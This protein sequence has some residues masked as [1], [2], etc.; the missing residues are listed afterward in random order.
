MRIKVLIV[1]LVILFAVEACS[2]KVDMPA[3]NIIERPS[4]N[5]ID[6]NDPNE[7]V[8]TV[9]V[10]GPGVVAQNITKIFAQGNISYGLKLKYITF[11]YNENSF[12]PFLHIGISPSLANHD[13][14]GAT[15]L[16][17]FLQFSA[18]PFHIV[19]LIHDCSE[20]E[21]EIW[22]WKYFYDHEEV[23][24]FHKLEVPL[25]KMTPNFDP[26]Q[27]GTNG[28]LDLNAVCNIEFLLKTYSE[29]ESSI[30]TLAN[31]YLSF[32]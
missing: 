3:I 13:W 12:E 28:R 19:V 21:S 4:R 5:I 2:S 14:S 26:T 1:C 10:Y 25:N 23:D 18:L 27:S 11:E 22:I 16:V 24:E 7:G 15:K 9:E 30:I 6:F 17:T 29:N 20:H 31:P 8:F 32:D